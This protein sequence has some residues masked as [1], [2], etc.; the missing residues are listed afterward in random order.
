MDEAAASLRALSDLA[1]VSNWKIV[2]IVNARHQ[3]GK[4]ARFSEIIGDGHFCA[5]TFSTE[6]DGWLLQSVHLH[7]KT[8]IYFTKQS[9][10][11]IFP[12]SGAL[13]QVKGLG[14]KRK[15]YVR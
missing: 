10:F 7:H 15:S 14:V 6:S 1:L 2:V 11:E 9:K 12:R 4:C 3:R 5:A 13:S 8:K